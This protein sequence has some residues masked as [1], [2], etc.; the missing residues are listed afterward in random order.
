MLPPPPQSGLDEW[1]LPPQA[2][3]RILI[4]NGVGVGHF[5]FTCKVPIENNLWAGCGGTEIPLLRQ[6]VDQARPEQVGKQ[7]LV[8]KQQQKDKK[9]T[10]L[11]V[12]WRR[13]TRDPYVL[14][15][16]LKNGQFLV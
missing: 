4:P 1:L 10:S 11:W 14:S 13:N 8:S 9:A 15:W 16:L 3:P 2:L 6:E 5:K 7:E 12:S